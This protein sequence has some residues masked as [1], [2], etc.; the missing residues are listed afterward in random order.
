[1]SGGDSIFILLES[2]GGGGGGGEG[3]ILV[4]ESFESRF[5]ISQQE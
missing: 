5:F 4:H 2:V 1:M 3:V